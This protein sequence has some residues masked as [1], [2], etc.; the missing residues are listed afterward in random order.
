MSIGPKAQETLRWWIERS[1]KRGGRNAGVFALPGRKTYR[2]T[3]YTLRVN[4]VC[5]RLGLTGEQR[6]TPNGLRHFAAT[7]IRARYGLEA[8]QAVLG[9]G[10]AK[11]TQIYA[12]VDTSAADRV[13]GEMG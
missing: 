11:T 3:T 9:H 13:A 8:A 10:D 7:A 5:D 6:W 4:A 2:P 1:E 12:E